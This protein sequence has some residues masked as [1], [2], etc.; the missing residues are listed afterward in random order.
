M[1]EPKAARSASRWLGWRRIFIRQTFANS[2]S[3]KAGAA[4]R[5][6]S[7]RSAIASASGSANSRAASAEASTT[8]TPVTG[9]ADNSGR[10]GGRVET[11]T[12]DFREELGGAEVR[13]GLDRFFDDGEQLPLQRPM[14]SLC[15][16][17]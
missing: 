7:S 8:L 2:K 6:P 14:V 10:V 15:P 9:G 5:A 16:P 4:N 13:L 11:K 17:L 12:P 3:S 1:R